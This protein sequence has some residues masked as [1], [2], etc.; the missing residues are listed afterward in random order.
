MADF[1]VLTKAYSFR[2][3]FDLGKSIPDRTLA[4]VAAETDGDIVAALPPIVPGCSV[5]STSFALLILFP[6]FNSP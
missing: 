3:L 6:L 5:L 2:S 1:D 4:I